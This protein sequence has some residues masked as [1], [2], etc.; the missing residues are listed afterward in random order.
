[1]S[2]SIARWLKY[3]ATNLLIVSNYCTN[4]YWKN[5]THERVYV[6]RT[7]EITGCTLRPSVCTAENWRYECCCLYMANLQHYSYSLCHWRSITPLQT[8]SV[9]NPYSR[10][11]TRVLTRAERNVFPWHNLEGI[12]Q[13]TAAFLQTFIH[14]CGAT[15]SLNTCVTKSVWHFFNIKKFYVVPTLRLCVLYG[16]QN[17]QQLLPYKTLRDWFL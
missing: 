3:Q 9:L 10:S 2:K 1:M 12:I 8:L 11:T 15:Q 4:S 13:K 16:S 17:K 7:D 14:F 5:E 6:N